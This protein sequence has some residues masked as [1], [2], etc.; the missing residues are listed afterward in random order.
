MID[1]TGYKPGNT[2]LHRL[3]PITK[4]MGVGCAIAATVLASAWAP[5]IGIP[6]LACVLSA[7]IGTGR[8]L[9]GLIR[10]LVPIVCAMFALQILFVRTGDILYGPITYD[11]IA[12]AS[13]ACLRLIGAAIPFV[14]LLATTRLTDLANACVEILH[15]PYR[16]A[17]TFTT[18]LRFIPLF[19]QEMHAIVETQ[20]TR[21]VALDTA[22]PLKRFTLML[23][24]CIPLLV[25]SVRKVDSIALAAEQRGFYLRTRASSYRR[26]P[27][28]RIDIVTISCCIALMVFCLIL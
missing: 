18:A 17:F 7:Y 15:L 3:N 6:V 1:I 5:L 4:L 10:L 8:R 27:L 19:S 2:L 23:P 24:I 14:L 11:G 13:K 28:T 25:T 22:S 21:G 9:A 12:S 26:F 16:Y 20:I